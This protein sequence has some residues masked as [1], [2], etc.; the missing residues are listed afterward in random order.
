[1]VELERGK[2]ETEGALS[3]AQEELEEA[4]RD[5][6]DASRRLARSRRDHGAVTERL[7]ET[8]Q[9]LAAARAE[10]AEAER[11]LSR[12]TEELAVTTEELESTRRELGGAEAEL[13]VLREELNTADAASADGSLASS[14][15]APQHTPASGEGPTAAAAAEA[16]VRRPAQAEQSVLEEEAERVTLVG[17][18]ERALLV[19]AAS[20]ARAEAE[21]L[22][23]KVRGLELEAAETRRS[24]AEA[25]RQLASLVAVARAEGGGERP[26]AAGSTR[27]EEALLLPPRQGSSVSDGEG[28]EADGVRELRRQ[29]ERADRLRNASEDKAASLLRRLAQVKA[30]ADLVVLEAERAEVKT[31]RHKAVG[32][33]ASL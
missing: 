9:A 4:C 11:A 1:M 28:G 18:A 12:T 33:G 16:G 7:E 13:A 30:E 8:R 31:H 17:A 5:L 20:E 22:R 6:E 15:L 23:G 27:T 24:L 26:A 32:W 10:L 19:E 2:R 21:A 14:G 3:V 25:N 29:L